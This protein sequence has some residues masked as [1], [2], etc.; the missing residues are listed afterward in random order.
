MRVILV[1]QLLPVPPDL[2]PAPVEAATEPPANQLPALM[3]DLFG[4]A[5]G[6]QRLGGG[7]GG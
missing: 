1:E 7:G 3:I 5:K 6:R 2:S 4:P